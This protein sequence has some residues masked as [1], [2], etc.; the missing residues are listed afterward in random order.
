MYLLPSV[1][2]SRTDSEQTEV[3]EDVLD[4]LQQKLGI[5]QAEIQHA[6]TI[7]QHN[8]LKVAYRLSMDKRRPFEHHSDTTKIDESMSVTWSGPTT[9]MPYS[10]ASTS[11]TSMTTSDTASCIQVLG[12]SLPTPPEEQHM[13]RMGRLMQWR[14]HTSSTSGTKSVHTE[15]STTQTTSTRSKRSTDGTRRR[16]V[17]PRWHFGIRSQGRPLEVMDEVYRALANIGMDWKTFDPFHVRAR[18]ISPDGLV[19]KIDLRLYTMDQHLYLLDFCQAHEPTR[20]SNESNT[21]TNQATTSKDGS[22]PGQSPF[23]FFD[24]C[25]QLIT[26]LALSS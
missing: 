19:V 12:S 25:S 3:D 24:A 16:T 6:L 2:I 11:P 22:F 21:C 23:P 10:Q 1:S 8:P 20:I 17:R 15:E 26:E 13:S 4:E 5:S 9:E 7:P 18:Y 14:R